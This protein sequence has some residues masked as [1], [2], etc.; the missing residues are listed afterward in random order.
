MSANYVYYDGMDPPALLCPV[1][2]CP[3]LPCVQ[4]SSSSP[5]FLFLTSY[6]LS[7]HSLFHPRLPS[8]LLDHFYPPFPQTHSSIVATNNTATVPIFSHAVSQLALTCQAWLSCHD[9]LSEANCDEVTGP[10]KKR[11]EVKSR[12]ITMCDSLLVHGQ[13]KDNIFLIHCILLLSHVMC[14]TS[15]DWDGMG[16]DGISE[17]SNRQ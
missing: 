3:V 8:L 17:H 14:A 12:E 6:L 9:Q 5:Y 16:W 2:P 10:L 4:T 15:C 7:F 11:I 13:G 1:L